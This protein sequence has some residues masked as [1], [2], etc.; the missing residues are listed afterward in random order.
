M[1]TDLNKKHDDLLRQLNALDD[2]IALKGYLKQL[3]D[4]AMDA[5]QYPDAKVY[6]KLHIYVERENDSDVDAKQQLDSI[7][8]AD[9]PDDLM[10]SLKQ[11]QSGGVWNPDNKDLEP[12]VHDIKLE[13]L[14]NST[15]LAIMD[16]IINKSKTKG[17]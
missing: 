15:F 11:I 7:M 10:K 3:T 4:A 2:K 5:L 14:D 12:I 17:K 13:C 1:G 16:S 6:C 9:N 8:K